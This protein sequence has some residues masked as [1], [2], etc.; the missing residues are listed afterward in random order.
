MFWLGSKMTEVW[1][2]FKLILFF[3]L[4][5]C[6]SHFYKIGH[7]SR[8][9][10]IFYLSPNSFSLSL[11]FFFY[12]M[13]R[14]NGKKKRIRQQQQPWYVSNVSLI[15]YCSMLLF[16]KSWMFNGLYHSLLYHFWTNLLTQRPSPDCC[17]LS[18][19][20]FR[21][22]RISNGVQTEWNLCDRYFWTK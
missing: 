2:I 17:F 20:G 22:K 3:Y 9:M 21:R 12:F 13:S 4:Q 1:T 6:P 5:K 11:Y 18:V 19:S 7:K 14:E 16:M 8:S 10:G 15:F